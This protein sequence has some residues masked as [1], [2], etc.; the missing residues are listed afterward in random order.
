MIDHEE[1]LFMNQP[2]NR[3]QNITLFV[4]SEFCLFVCFLTFFSALNPSQ[5]LLEDS[6]WTSAKRYSSSLTLD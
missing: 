4:I 3:R 2:K 6:G 5:F 1:E